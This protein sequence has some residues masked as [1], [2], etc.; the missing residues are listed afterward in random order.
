MLPDDLVQAMPAEARIHQPASSK[1][2]DPTGTSNYLVACVHFINKCRF[3]PVK[4]HIG[5]RDLWRC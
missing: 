3:T 5:K 4:T 2:L 1:F